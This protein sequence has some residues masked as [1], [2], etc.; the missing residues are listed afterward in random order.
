MSHDVLWTPEKQRESAIPLSPLM[1][2]LEELEREIREIKRT[3][4]MPEQRPEN[5]RDVTAECEAIQDDLNHRLDGSLVAIRHP[6]Y[7]F[8][9]VRLYRCA[10]ETAVAQD[11]FIVERREL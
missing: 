10:S 9:K 2:R 5:W 1:Q 8:R 7:R 4:S 6:R 11:A 3:M